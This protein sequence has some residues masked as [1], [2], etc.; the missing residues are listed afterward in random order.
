MKRG[1]S[2]MFFYY[3]RSS[4][5]LTYHW[6]DSFRRF[7]LVFTVQYKRTLLYH[8]A[9]SQLLLLVLCFSLVCCYY[10]YL[11]IRVER[12]GRRC[13]FSRIYVCFETVILLLFVTIQ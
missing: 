1:N 13:G 8:S 5:E 10:H 12:M 11:D 6:I 7:H 4:Y 9:Y 2:F 3:C